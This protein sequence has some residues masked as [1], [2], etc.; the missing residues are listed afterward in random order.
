MGS[1]FEPV[2]I[3]IRIE[4]ESRL[5]RTSRAGRASC[6]QTSW[7]IRAAVRP[8]CT[9][10]RAKHQRRVFFARGQSGCFSRRF[11]VLESP[12]QTPLRHR[13]SVGNSLSRKSGKSERERLSLRKCRRAP[14]P[15]RGR[16]ERRRRQ[17][18]GAPPFD[19]FGKKSAYYANF[20]NWS[21]IFDFG[22]VKKMRTWLDRRA[23]GETRMRNSLGTESHPSALDTFLN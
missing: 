17:T 1:L 21:G 4:R 10:R 18:F 11:Q 13:E 5:S 2:E 6:A 22:I 7:T 12:K 19:R 3:F 9:S 23:K 8:S 14:V 16:R 20:V 15:G